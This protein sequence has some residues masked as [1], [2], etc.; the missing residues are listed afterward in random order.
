MHPVLAP[1]Q[2][3]VFFIS[4]LAFLSTESFTSAVTPQQARAANR[5]LPPGWTAGVMNHGSYYNWWTI[6]QRPALYWLSRSCLWASNIFLYGSLY[7][8]LW[9][10][11]K[12]SSEQERK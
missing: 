9:L 8:L 1:V 7:W 10:H 6:D 12:S 4:M 2:V 5:P 11:W 3:F